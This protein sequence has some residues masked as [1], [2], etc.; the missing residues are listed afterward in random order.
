MSSTTPETG[1]AVAGGLIAGYRPPV[2]SYDELRLRGGGLREPWP[3]FVSGIERLGSAGLDQRREQARR[4]LRENG[5]TYNVYGETQGPDRPWELD[6]L[7]LVVSYEEWDRLSK[8]LAQR[9]TVLNA[10]LADLYGPQTL[11]ERG[12][13]PPE[14]VFAHPGFLVP[15]HGLKVPGDIYLHLYAGHV[16]RGP[17]GG[18]VVLADRTQ[19]PSGAGYAVENRVIM[20][21]ILPQD[22]HALYVER[23]ASFF[24]ALRETLH[25]IAPRNRENPRVVLLSPGTRS[26]TY[27]EDGYLSRYLGYSLAEGGDLTVRGSQVFLKTLGGL[28]PVDVILRRVP[29]E[30]VDPLELKPDSQLGVAGLV[31]AARE[32]QVAVANA[33]GSGYLESLALMAF[34]PQICRALRSE[35]LQLPSIG[36]WWCGLPEHLQY[37]ESH[38][39]EL[40][41]RPA[42]RHR[43]LAPILGWRLTQAEKS[44]LIARI[45]QRPGAYVGQA[46]IVRS[47]APVWNGSRLEPWRLGLR[48]FAVA[49]EGQYRVMPGALSRMSPQEGFV[50]E[51]V[52]EG[53]VS[54]DVWVLASAPVKSVTLLRPNRAAVQLRRSGNDLPSR[55]ADNLYW[56][57]RFV[58]RAESKVRHL[59]SAIVRLTTDVAPVGPLEVAALI[60]SL[61][62]NNDWHA[63]PNEEGELLVERIRA[64]A[65]SF[66]FDE[67]HE[68]GLFRTLRSLRRTG[69][70]IR[71]RLS[72]DSWRIVNQLHSGAL[73]GRP[74]EGARPGDLLVLLN[75]MV[76]LL[77]AFSG[78]ATESMTRA[79]SW[80]FL[81]MG[82]R[83]ER[84]QQTLQLLKRTLVEVRDDV[85]PPLE[86]VLEIANST[87][88]YRYRYLTSL[89]LAPVLDLILVDETNPRAVGFQLAA[90]AEH[91]KQLPGEAA[92]AEQRPEP[93]IVLAAQAAL[94]LCDVDAFCEPDET[95][96]RAALG[97]FLEQESGHLRR[98]SDAITQRYLSHTGPSHQL[99]MM[100]VSVP[101]PAGDKT[102]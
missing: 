76:T 81:D 62:E 28:L 4:L 84:A 80:R 29:D 35:D 41:I 27:F 98:L 24:I 96:R 6:P 70:A 9:V 92:D 48:T 30:E 87:M 57:G 22:F 43:S 78:L 26:A 39:N 53:E 7:P 63:E 77:S 16:V 52:A 75:Q 32:G 45:R 21:R 34:L 12:V 31:Q 59:R 19:G 88:T 1:A 74:T 99:G 11:V 69:A 58:E 85:A 97:D 46:Q 15:C 50:G 89:Q 3:R 67:T 25:S 23:L 79:Q 64:E 10:V 90:L 37:V 44:E 82:R 42:F 14:L 36:V 86:A 18:W 91:V 95:G 20:S 55:A 2:N 13:L 83:I 17:D 8:A 94:R 40:A 56:L 33:L 61:S 68:S 101:S 65:V 73:F 49:H 66:I 38:L 100:A 5:V 54:K 72:I 47:T 51:S 71:D 93:R 60:E 102:P